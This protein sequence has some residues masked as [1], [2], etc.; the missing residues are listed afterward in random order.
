M[1]QRTFSW[2]IAV[3]EAI[4]WVVVYLGLRFVIDWVR[5][6]SASVAC[7]RMGLSEWPAIV[8]LVAGALFA[9][10]GLELMRVRRVRKAVCRSKESGTL[11]KPL[12]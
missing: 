2:R 6:G 4:T 12:R 5:F 9:G 3:A 7:G 11:K 1:D 8:V 10:S